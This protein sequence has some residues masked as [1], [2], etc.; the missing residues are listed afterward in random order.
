MTT[1]KHGMV[2]SRIPKKYLEPYRYRSR[3]KYFDPVMDEFRRKIELYEK[4]IEEPERQPVRHLLQ[5]LID[6]CWRKAKQVV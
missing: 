1:T 5:E 4:L 6:E 2:N 3:Q